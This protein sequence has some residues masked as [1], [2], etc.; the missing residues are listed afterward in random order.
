MPSGRYIC[1]VLED[2]RKMY[3]TRNFAGLMGAIEDAQ[4]MAYRMEAALGDKKSIEDYE[5]Q[6]SK[7]K[8]EVRALKKEAKGMDKLTH[9][10]PRPETDLFPAWGWMCPLCEKISYMNKGVSDPNIVT[11][12]HC[13]QESKA[14]STS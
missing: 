6:A 14:C 8:K 13:K 9:L 1:E 12:I 2:M 3:K 5:E 4:R 11:C 10:E 7:L